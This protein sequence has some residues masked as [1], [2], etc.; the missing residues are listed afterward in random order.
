MVM[1]VWNPRQEGLG[2]VVTVILYTKGRPRPYITFAQKGEGWVGPKAVISKGKF[3]TKR[4]F[5][6]PKNYFQSRYEGSQLNKYMS[7]NF[8]TDLNFYL[9][10]EATYC[11]LLKVYSQTRIASR[12]VTSVYVTYPSTCVSSFISCLCTSTMVNLS[13]N[14]KLSLIIDIV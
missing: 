9:I 11:T 14:Y 12:F 8:D 3:S 4:G 2:P 6:I 7:T 1:G 5:I 10:S 13:S